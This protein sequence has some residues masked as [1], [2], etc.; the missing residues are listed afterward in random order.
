MSG[1]VAL[2]DDGVRDAVGVRVGLNLAALFA[3]VAQPF[4]PD[5]SAIVLDALAVKP[6]RR[7]W[8]AAG[9]DGLALLDVDQAIAP[10]DVLFKKIEDAD[11]AAWAERF[12]AG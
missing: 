11:V 3:L 1:I 7:V 9:M 12:G 2:F 10:P 8:P 6:E 5:A 4:I